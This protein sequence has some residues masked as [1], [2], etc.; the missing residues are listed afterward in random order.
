MSNIGIATSSMLIDLNI[1]V[2]TAKKLDKSVSQEVD[3]SKEAKFR[4][5][6]YNKN[7]LAGTHQLDRIV[8][9]AANT[10][11]WHNRHTLPWSDAGTRLLPME[12]FLSYKNMLNDYEAEF[13]ALVA[14]FLNRYPELVDA[15]AFNLGKLFNREEYPT[16]EQISNK[17]KF[18]YMFSPVPT[19]GDFRV[20]IGETA[21]AELKNQFEA[22]ANAKVERAMK[23]AWDRLHDVLVHM[24]ERLTDKEDGTHKEFRDSLVNNAVE[25]TS[26]L[27]SLNITK[28][29]KLEQA[30][31][32]LSNILLGVD[33]KELRKHQSIRQEVKTCV[34]DILSKFSF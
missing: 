1:S 24:S 22:G 4:A 28:D 26:M 16:V 12:S 25:L 17:F 30:R 15:A 6:N 2:W 10:R 32:E 19:S 31:R 5:G 14:Q 27:T 11:L 3:E 21:L 13:N 8:K 33:A 29:P 9:F 18:S 7:L 34:D 20:D 23:E